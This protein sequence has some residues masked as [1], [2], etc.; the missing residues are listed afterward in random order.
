MNAGDLVHLVTIQTPGTPVSDG[1]GAFTTPW[2]SLVPDEWASITPATARSLERAMAG[3]IVA[4]ATHL[5]RLHYREDVT[6]LCRV[7]HRRTGH[8]DVDASGNPLAAAR[9]FLLTGVGNVDEQ[10]VEL[11]LAAV[12]TV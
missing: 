10:D 3:T 5:I 4:T 9:V 6:T 12:E 11:L 8:V 1:D 7:L 2:I